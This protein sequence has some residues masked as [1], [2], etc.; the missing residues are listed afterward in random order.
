VLL[1][2]HATHVLTSATWPG[3]Q[4][5][6]L[7]IEQPSLN[8]LRWIEEPMIVASLVR[9]D[10][11]HVDGSWRHCSEKLVEIVEVSLLGCHD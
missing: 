2:L 1:S 4:D 8:G 5:A 3:R 9:I 11:R 10:R 7:L 6:P